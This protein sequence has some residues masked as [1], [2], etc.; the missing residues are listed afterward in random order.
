[1]NRRSVAG[2]F[3]VGLFMAFVPI[4][5]QMAAAAALA[6]L[7]RVN[8]PISVALVWITNPLTMAPVFYSAY[9]LGQWVLDAP[10]VPMHFE[11]SLHWLMSDMLL[12]WRPFLL[13]CFI[14][15][16]VAAAS[17]YVGVRAFW[18][19]YIIRKLEEKR[20]RAPREG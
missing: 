2:A 14:L 10:H 11:L 18:R 19:L 1:M 7:F 13:G 3:A 4:P 15:S 5:S 8:L 6:I 16:A 12:V 17:G 9:K 20:R